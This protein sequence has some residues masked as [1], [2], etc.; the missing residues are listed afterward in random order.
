MNKLV[1]TRKV[2]NDHIRR[3]NRR[4]SE[5]EREDARRFGLYGIIEED[6]LVSVESAADGETEE[7]KDED[8]RRASIVSRCKALLPDLTYKDGRGEGPGSSKV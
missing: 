1:K 4:C 8:R 5:S 7:D 6:V 3:M 2:F